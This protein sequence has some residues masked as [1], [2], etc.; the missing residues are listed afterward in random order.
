MD[1]VHLSDFTRGEVLRVVIPDTPHPQKRIQ[2]QRNLLKDQ[3]IERVIILGTDEHNSYVAV[4]CNTK[5]KKGAIPIRVGYLS[6]YAHIKPFLHIDAEVLHRN[7]NATLYDRDQVLLQLEEKIQRHSISREKRKSES[8]TQSVVSPLTTKATIEEK[9][10]RENGSHIPPQE[11]VAQ[12]RISSGAS[13]SPQYIKGYKVVSLAGLNRKALKKQITLADYVCDECLKCSNR[14]VEFV[15]FIQINEAEG[16][17]V[18]GH[19]C[20]KCDTFYE[21]RGDTLKQLFAEGFSFYDY[22]L[23]TDYLFLQYSQKIRLSHTIKSASIAVHLHCKET[24]ENRLITIVSDR[25]DKNHEQ[26]VFHYSDWFARRLLYEIF[27]QSRSMSVAG[28]TFNLLKIFRLDWEDYSL[29]SQLKIDTIV[30]RT[31]GGLYGG[32]HQRGTELVDILL[33]SPFTDCF[34]V[35]HATYDTE[36]E[37]YYMDAKV[38]RGFIEKYGNPGVKLAAYQRGA[39]DF[40][41]MREESILHAYGY[42]V[43]N[44]GL[45]TRARQMLLSE[46]MD[47]GIMSSY[48]ILSLLDLNIS[49]HPGDKYENARTDWELDKQFVMEYKVNP[50]RFVVATIGL[51]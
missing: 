1:C 18:P 14:L 38:F 44:N 46:V 47:L 7:E 20:T 17:R 50:D 10:K 34:E 29:L 35:A 43:G 27:K 41:S 39:R 9:R 5:H 42:V 15:N 51:Y 32:I 21:N 40:S 11:K 48:S 22:T 36:N 16:I 33:Y 3:K 23:N 31:G 12:K 28:D 49:M 13:Q 6:F 30:L 24:K 4:P 26:D 25:T 8:K 45:S 37:I 19:Y 2:R